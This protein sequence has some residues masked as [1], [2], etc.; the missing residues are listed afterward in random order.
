MTRVGHRLQTCHEKLPTQLIDL[1]TLAGRLGVGERHIRRLVA[2]RRIP[3]YKW[4]RLLRFDCDEIDQW[5]NQARVEVGGAWNG[6]PGP[7][8]T[9]VSTVACRCGS[10]T[11]RSRHS[12]DTARK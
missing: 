8:V 11:K 9:R 1:P 12:T 2:E 4:G 7:I 5:L 3:Y 10:S 6:K